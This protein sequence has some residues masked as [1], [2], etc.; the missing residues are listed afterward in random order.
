MDKPLLTVRKRRINN[1]DSMKRSDFLGI[2]GKKQI[3]EFQLKA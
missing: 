2:L 1:L 3:A